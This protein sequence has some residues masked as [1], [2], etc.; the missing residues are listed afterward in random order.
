MLVAA[1]MTLLVNYK[2]LDVPD[3]VAVVVDSFGPTWGW[4]AKMIKVGAI[5]GLTSVVLVLMYGQTRIFYTMA[6]DGLLPRV[7]AT[8]HPKYQTPWINTLLVGLI[9]ALAAG[10]FDINVLGD[11]TSVGTLAAF[12][13]VCLSVIYLRRS[14][15]ELPRGFTVPFYPVLPVLGILSCFYLI[16]TVEAR[17][18]QF[19]G[20]F[21]IGAV[22]LYFIYGMRNSQLQHGEKQIDAPDMTEL[23]G[24]AVD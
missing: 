10:F 18:L 15:P 11:M 23:P 2:A 20:Y 12:A 5:I 24:P 9:T 17:V 6:R 13:I 16:T 3:P 21:M 7:F 22:A 8:I 19:F 14:A 1:I 4:F